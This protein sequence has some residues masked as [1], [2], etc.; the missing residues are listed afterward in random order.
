[1]WKKV[2]DQNGRRRDKIVAFRMSRAENEDLNM[3]V[4]LSGLTKQNYLISRMLQREIVVIGNPRVYK[5]L[6]D[7]M[8]NIL[9]ELKR[10]ENN[11]KPNID[12]ITII[13]TVAETL[14]GLKQNDEGE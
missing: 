14:N 7:R 1:M 8:D 6:R 2:Y 13:E 11:E 12:I 5:A 9:T 10:L 4:K 3:R